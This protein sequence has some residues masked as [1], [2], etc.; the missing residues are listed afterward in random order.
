MPQLLNLGS[1]SLVSA[2]GSDVLGGARSKFVLYAAGGRLG[3]GPSRHR[4]TP[5]AHALIGGI[6]MN[7]QTAAGG[8]NGF[9]LQTG[10]GADWRWNDRISLRAEGDYVRTQLYSSSQNNFQFGF[11]AVIHF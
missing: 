4:W 1:G 5:W 8:K 3:W 9:P 2:F 10:G 6:H 11:G 7:P